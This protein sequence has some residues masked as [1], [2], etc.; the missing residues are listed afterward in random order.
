MVTFDELSKYLDFGEIESNRRVVM[1]EYPCA[2]G[3]A[4]KISGRTDELFI[5]DLVNRMCFHSALFVLKEGHPFK[6][7]CY[8]VRD[9]E[10]K[11][12]EIGLIV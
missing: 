11:P 4:F 6:Y 8:Y 2:M 3:I 1:L 7:R 10:V 12:S 5:S 9:S